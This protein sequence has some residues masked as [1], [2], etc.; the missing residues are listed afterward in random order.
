MQDAIKVNL[1]VPEGEGG[2]HPQP[3][4]EGEAVRMEGVDQLKKGVGLHSY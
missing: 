4:V 2:A 3:Q 1:V